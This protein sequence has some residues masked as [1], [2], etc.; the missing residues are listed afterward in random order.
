MFRLGSPFEGMA[1][2]LFSEVGIAPLQMGRL[3][4]LWESP[5]WMRSVGA[6]G[7]ILAFGFVILWRNRSL[8]DDSVEATLERPAIAVLYG[9]A[10]HLVVA[11]VGFYLADQFGRYVLSPA[12][13]TLYG[14]ILAFVLA[15]TFAAWGFTVIGTAIV[16][17][18]HTLS[19]WN[20]LVVGAAFAAL[21]ALPDP[22]Y[23]GPL[24][25]VLVSIA[26]GGRI[27]RWVHVAE[28]VEA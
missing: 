9:V 15:I 16:E 13:A 1:S 17:S 11:F 18:V 27:R 10:A 20:G 6:F 19:K 2:N 7:L 21:L 5:P 4:E 14:T 28:A 12:D 22:W 3:I 24:W 8:I 26:I 23:G 25:L